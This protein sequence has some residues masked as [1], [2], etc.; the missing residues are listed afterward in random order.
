[1]TPII[2]DRSHEDI[3][4]ATAAVSVNVTKGSSDVTK[5]VPD[6]FSPLKVVLGAISAVYTNDKVRL[7]PLFE[8]LL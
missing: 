1:L 8:S 7:N 2:A 3:V 5:E 6:G 4:D